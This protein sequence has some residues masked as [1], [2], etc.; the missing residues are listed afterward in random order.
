MRR[1]RGIFAVLSCGVVVLLDAGSND[2]VNLFG[3]CGSLGLGS[4]SLLL[5]ACLYLVKF[6]GQRT[7]HTAGAFVLGLVG[8]LVTV[9][10]TGVIIR[11]MIRT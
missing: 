6:R 3:L 4:I 11:K 10:S 7:R 9:G 5:P 2:L 8:L 1:R